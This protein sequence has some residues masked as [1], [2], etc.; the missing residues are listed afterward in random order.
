[1]KSVLIMK[2]QAQYHPL[3]YLK[4]LL[5]DSIKNGTQVYEQTTATDVEY[6]KLHPS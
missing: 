2:N 1:M 6:N 4:A 5:D 3:K